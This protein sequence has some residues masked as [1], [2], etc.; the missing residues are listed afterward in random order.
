MIVLYYVGNVNEMSNFILH[1]NMTFHARPRPQERIV[2]HFIISKLPIMYK[3]QLL[4]WMMKYGL[5]VY[6]QP[7]PASNNL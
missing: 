2:F 4:L 1:H 7:R 6:L 3:F 5:V